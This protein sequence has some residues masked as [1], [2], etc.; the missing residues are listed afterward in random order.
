[1][2]R[3]FTILTGT[4]VAAAAR[5]IGAAGQK[6]ADFRSD[7]RSTARIDCAPLRPLSE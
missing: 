7:G 2:D 3:N 6:P 1:M 4:Y 5:P